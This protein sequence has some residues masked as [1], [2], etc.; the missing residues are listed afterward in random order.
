MQRLLLL[1]TFVFVFDQSTKAQAY[2]YHTFPDSNAVWYL[3]FFN[4]NTCGSGGPSSGLC[5]VTTN[6]LSIDTVIK[7]NL[8]HKVKEGNLTKGYIRQDISSKKVYILPAEN[9]GNYNDST[10]YIAYNGN[11]QIGDIIDS[12]YLNNQ[13]GDTVFVSSIDSILTDAGYRKFIHV[14]INNFEQGTYIE[15]IG[16]TSGLFN[17][18]EPF[19]ESGFSLVCFTVNDTVKFK[20]QIIDTSHNPQSYYYCDSATIITDVKSTENKH[21]YLKILANPVQETLSFESENVM[22]I[23]LYNTLG[24]KLIE[25]KIDCIHSTITT[26]LDFKTYPIGLY[27]LYIKTIDNEVY[28]Y[29][30]LKN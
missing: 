10:E 14:S 11:W 23:H 6:E 29:K 7:G 15:G 21:Y 13:F 9:N 2:I 5:Y 16:L 25:K 30:I 17:E 28:T 18:I 8:Y 22:D 1:L 3:G 27:F 26:N 20:V 24:Y 4:P 12:T 19:F